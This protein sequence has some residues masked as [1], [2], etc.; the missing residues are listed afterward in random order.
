MS[1]VLHIER[2][3]IDAAALGGER[4][5][6]VRAALERELV[7]RLAAPGAGDALRRLGSIDALPPQRL[8]AARHPRELLGGRIAGAVGEGLGITAKGTGSRPRG[9]GRVS[10]DP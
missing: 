10:S 1:I 4:A 2:L 3:V 7:A 6:D 8:A 5:A 9:A